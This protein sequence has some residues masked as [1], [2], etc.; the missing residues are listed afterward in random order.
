MNLE[1][2]PVHT[3]EIVNKA[4]SVFLKHIGEDV[5]CLILHGSAVKG[6]VI[7]G[8]SDLDLKLYVKDQLLKNGNLPAKLIFDIQR[9]LQS[10]NYEPFNYIQCDVHNDHLPDG[11]IGP[12]PGSYVTVS[13]HLPVPEAT[14]EQLKESAVVSLKELKTA[15]PFLMNLLD[16]GHERIDRTVR[17]MSTQLFPLLYQVVTLTEQ[18][19]IR[20]WNLP[21]TE[22]VPLL[23]TTELQEIAADFFDQLTAYYV[24]K[25]DAKA[26]IL[27]ETGVDFFIESKSWFERGYLLNKER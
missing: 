2:L 27:I 1:M 16:L 3:Q 8:S 18:D 21:K 17:L 22:L 19:S 4:N 6:G 14:H 15:P 10:I 25:S 12:V 5:L 9:D 23:P 26:L 11:F 7:N 13:G 24:Q 20:V